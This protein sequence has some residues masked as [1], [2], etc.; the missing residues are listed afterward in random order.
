RNSCGRNCFSIVLPRREIPKWFSHQSRGCWIS[1]QLPPHWFNSSFLGFAF[2]AVGISNK[3]KPLLIAMRFKRLGTQRIITKCSKRQ[4]TSLPAVDFG[5][6]PVRYVSRSEFLR[7]VE[8]DME[9]L[10]EDGIEFQACL[11]GVCRNSSSGEYQ[12]ALKAAERY[13]FGENGWA[14]KNFVEV[15]KFGVRLVYK[16]AKQQALSIHNSED[17]NNMGVFH[18]DLDRSAGVQGAS[19]ATT[20]KRIRDDLNDNDYDAAAGSSGSPGIDDQEDLLNLNSK[21]LRMDTSHVLPTDG[22]D[23]WLPA[24]EYDDKT[25]MEQAARISKCSSTLKS[26]G[27]GNFQHDSLLAEN[28][29]RTKDDILPQDPK[30]NKRKGK[31]CKLAIGSIENIVAHGTVYERIE[32]NE[33]I[34]TVP[35]GESNVRVSVE[36]VIQKDAPFPVPIPD[37]MLIVGEAVGFFVAWPKNL[38]LVG[39]EGASINVE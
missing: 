35:L 3:Y 28:M 34:H 36:V 27:R 30:Q 26:G 13:C 25:I 16:E 14:G 19:S 37:E 2:A 4:I 23:A 17:N 21:R 32:H 38:V 20:S 9:Q 29:V 11:F 7:N 10:N 5:N 1:F 6:L 24:T 39:D 33:A 22:D 31:P 8:A 15:E 18:G 12:L